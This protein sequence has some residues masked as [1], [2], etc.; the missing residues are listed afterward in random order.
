MSSEH[1]TI[2]DGEVLFLNSI[3]GRISI[4]FDVGTRDE[5]QLQSIAKEVHYFEP[6]KEFLDSLKEKPNSNT[7]SYYNCFGLA[8]KN[9]TKD[10]YLTHESFVDRAQ[11]LGTSEHTRLRLKTGFSYMQSKNIETVDFLKIDTEGYEL[12]VL[13]GFGK[14]L[15]NVKII[16]FEY[17]GTYADAGYK[18]IDV[19]DYLQPYGFV[20]FARLEL[21]GEMTP[22]TDFED[23]YHYSNFITYNENT[24]PCF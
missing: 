2:T 5:S 3:E 24:T 1:T 9:S 21:S 18:L 8:D 7:K 20:N 23:N 4:A 10:Y 14:A 22:T 11:T 13:K 19:I 6:K 12:Q 16:Q 17:G 15:S